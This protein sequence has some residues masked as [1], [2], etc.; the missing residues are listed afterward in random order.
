MAMRWTTS[1]LVVSCLFFACS[2]GSGRRTDD[3]GGPIGG[4]GDLG[5]IGDGDGDIAV[6][7]GD[8]GGGTL[9]PI[10]GTLGSDVG[11]TITVMGTL[12]PVQFTL[13]DSKGDPIPGADWTTDDTRI[14][15][16]SSDGV[17]TASGFVGGVV[18]I[19]ATLGGS[20]LSTQLTVNV[21]ITENL[22]SVSTSDQEA[23][24]AGGTSDAA[25]KRLY[26]YAG[27][28]YPRGVSAPSLQFAGTAATST[29]VEITAPHYIYRQ[30]GGASSPLRATLSEEV[31]KGLSLTVRPGEAAVVKFTKNGA[32]GASGPVESNWYF[33]SASLKG[34]VYY[35][36]YNFPTPGETLPHDAAIMSMRPGQAAQVVKRGCTTCHSVS[37]EGNVMATG[38]DYVP[39]AG[40]GYAA[41]EGYNPVD[42]ATYDLS[43]D[44][45]TTLRNT[46]SEGRD[47]SFLALSPDGSL[48]LTNG[49]P[50]GK[51]E[52]LTTH[53]IHAEQGFAS[54]LID[55]ST[56]ETIPST[57]LSD[58][59]TYAQ[60]PAFSH[61]GKRVAFSNGDK[62][63]SN[64]NDRVISVMDVD[65]SQSPPVF[66]NLQDVVSHADNTA[67][68]WPTFLPDGNAFVYHEGDSF[69]SNAFVA[70]ANA[71]TL[72]R[73]AEL[74]LKDLASGAVSNLDSLNGRDASGA[75]YLPYG[76]AEEGE[77][78]Y[79]PNV[80][81]VAV[82]GYYWVLFTSRR[83]YG[84]TIAPGGTIEDPHDP[85]GTGAMP[86]PR[87][88]LW[89]AAI[90]VNYSGSGDPSHP[91]FY[92][93]GQTLESGNMRGFTA[94]APCKAD[95]QDCESGSDCCGGF[96][97]ETSRDASGQPVLSCVPPPEAC[98]NIDEPCD[99]PADCCDTSLLCVNNLCTLPTPIIVK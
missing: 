99:T 63:A 11:D 26:P 62:L 85:W 56:G 29:Y 17:F 75:Y 14:G 68:A 3:D 69:D 34:I 30:F 53:G 95:G 80:L 65:L 96:C 8:S 47:Y 90:D 82:G 71:Q 51:W 24:V 44:G 94:M 33:A 45:Q 59:V 40:T 74:K 28:V 10:N 9:P 38:L 57:T 18:T 5:G 64:S 35:S 49:I 83:A 67:V 31:W 86:S 78:N 19:T 97:R 52:P 4:D 61:D 60:Y 12:T 77:M 66:S 79:E 32:G 1:A 22:A 6:G 16:I 89:L 50:A 13:K 43:E 15:S 23:L 39:N 54:K 36:T 2:A 42:S 46:S 21:E 41:S 98:S 91:A 55:T 87:K 7:D 73:F 76:E 92:L 81:P 27:T 70:D 84:N 37:S 20:V 93:S 72:K 88:K 25:L 48:G 58:L